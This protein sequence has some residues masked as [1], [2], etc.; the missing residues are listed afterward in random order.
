MTAP[1]TTAARRETV[2]PPDRTAAVL[3]MAL[4][5]AEAV[6][7]EPDM[8]ELA[9]V[10]ATQ[11]AAALHA[12]QTLVVAMQEEV[13]RLAAR[14]DSAVGSRP[15]TLT[16][17][18]DAL[19]RWVA[20]Q[21][22]TW[23]ADSA[24]EALP[25]EGAT[26]A[27]LGW[28]SALAV[29]ALHHQGHAVAVLVALNARAAPRFTT[30]DARMAVL[31]AAQAVVGFDRAQLLS[32]LED[33]TRG[34]EAL[35]A[36]SAAVNVPAPP[37][38]LVRGMSAH[39][40]RFMKADG[41]RGGL[42]GEPGSPEADVMTSTGYWREGRF[43]AAERRWGPC[44]GIPGQVLQSEFP[45]LCDDYR[46]DPLAEPELRD[47]HRV[48]HALC[49]PIKK[50]DLTVLGFYEL[51]RG[52]AGPPFTWQDAAFLESLAN[53]TAVAIENARLTSALSTTAAEVRTLSAHNVSRLEAERAHIARE[54]HDEAGQALVGVKL[55]LQALTAAIPD[56]MPAVRAPLDELR[57]QVNA[58]TSRIRH[59]ATRLRPPSLDQLGLHTALRQLLDEFADRTGLAVSQALEPLP[60]R[61]SA[62]HETALYRVVQ[63]ALTNI[64]HHAQASRVEITL[65][66]DGR[67]LLLRIADDGVG[68]DPT[69]PASGLGLLGIGERVRM[70][71][72]SFTLES[73]PGTGTV[74]TIRVPPA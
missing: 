41:A 28:R 24:T 49:V 56:T 45:Y 63:E 55:A 6:T 74:L 30:I 15:A 26:L 51:H 50:S 18:E 53:S 46:F 57:T 42:V 73:S 33:W 72:G 23:R 52:A 59:L 16:T 27:S 11:L 4:A 22:A 17:A 39:V 29:P 61:L 71:A 2:V 67:T 60:G 20:R 37:A 25:V 1:A 3:D 5:N 40:A 31:M 19:V 38:T 68:M 36:F 48:R 54:L 66:L 21:R 8:L 14:W 7:R 9:R 62:D 69:L 70:L 35:L 12:E 64:V 32:Q 58:A 43:T 47:V 13:P 34:M 65:A 44:E 10:L